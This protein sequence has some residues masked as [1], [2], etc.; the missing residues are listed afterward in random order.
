MTAQS[1]PVC[2]G[3]GHYILFSCAVGCCSTPNFE[4]TSEVEILRS[5]NG[6]GTVL[7]PAREFPLVSGANH[8]QLRQD[9]GVGQFRGAGWNAAGEQTA[10]ADARNRGVED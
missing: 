5:W 9:G 4:R 1:L 6:S 7:R 8:G 10:E 2:A 3:A